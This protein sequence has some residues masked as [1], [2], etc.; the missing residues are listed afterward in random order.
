MTSWPG[1]DPDHD[2]TPEEQQPEYEV[3]ERSRKC[4]CRLCPK[5]KGELALM[6]GYALEPHGE[7][8]F[9]EWY[10]CQNC[11]KCV[12][13]EDAIQTSEC[14]NCQGVG[15]ITT[16]EPQTLAAYHNLREFADLHLNGGKWEGDK[17]CERCNGYGEVECADWF[18][19]GRSC[20]NCRGT[21]QIKGHNLVWDSAHCGTELTDFLKAKGMIIKEQL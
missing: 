1:N 3:V 12:P 6:S 5:C 9:E 13:L 20:P 21:G 11:G 2:R 8:H 15:F 18:G 17:K 7:R 19:N 16:F 14:D 4:E 10:E